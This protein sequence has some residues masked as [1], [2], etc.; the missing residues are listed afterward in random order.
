MTC[1]ATHDVRSGPPSVA[2]SYSPAGRR[3]PGVGVPGLAGVSASA[4]ACASASGSGQP[5]R[6]TT[7]ADERR[8]R[9]TRQQVHGCTL[10]DGGRQS[11]PTATQ[12]IIYTDAARLVH[13]AG[14]GALRAELLE[15]PRQRGQRRAR[16]RDDRPPTS[17]A[18]ARHRRLLGRP[19]AACRRPTSRPEAEPQAHP[20]STTPRPLEVAAWVNRSPRL[21]HPDAEPEGGQRS[22]GAAL[23]TL[24]CAACHTISGAGD[25]LAEAPTP[26]L[27]LSTPTQVVEAIRTGPAQHAPLRRQHHR[28]AGARTSSPT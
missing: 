10:R 17:R 4:S 21:R 3:S 12:Y 8:A 23:F 22:D 14:A 19:P 7:S 11:S 1:L 2:A 9:P 25:A 16:Q 15:L 24:N 28:R 26:R 27:P 6:Q 18:S 5:R 13:H 20:A